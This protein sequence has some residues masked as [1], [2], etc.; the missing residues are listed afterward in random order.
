MIALFDWMVGQIDETLRRHDLVDNTLLIVTSDNGAQ[1]TDFY[2]NSWGHKPNG[3]LR[4]Q[5][6]DIWDGGH[7]E[8][9][10]ARWPGRIAPGSVSDQLICLGDLM[11]TCA[12]IVETEL[13]DGAGPDSFNLLPILQGHEEPV[14]ETLV[15]H[16]G[17]GMHSIRRGPWK[18]IEALGSG[19]FTQPARIESVPDGPAGQLYNVAEDIAEKHNLWHEHPGLV[20][21]LRATLAKL[22]AAG[23]S[24]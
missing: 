12:A 17:D 8:P 20:A 18:Y 16:S 7:R 13:P 9:F 23:R 15:H 19:G 14:R 6:A 24:R 2:G 10:I 22:V 11:A 21:E 4:G 5:K 3:E 1:L